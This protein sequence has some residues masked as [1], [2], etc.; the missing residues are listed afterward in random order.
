MTQRRERGRFRGNGGVIGRSVA[1]E[2]S[3]GPSPAFCF[4]GEGRSRATTHTTGVRGAPGGAE[5]RAERRWGSDTR[6]R[7]P[8][9]KRSGAAAERPRIKK[10]NSP[11]PTKRVGSV[12]IRKAASI[13]QCEDCTR[14][15]RMRPAGRL[16][17]AFA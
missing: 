14:R 4:L 9:Y 11:A 15:A 16:L 10:H 17:L 1:Q 7:A 8:L 3:K 12:A 2:A 5:G 6:G 13:A